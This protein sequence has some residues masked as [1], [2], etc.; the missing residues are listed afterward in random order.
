MLVTAAAVRHWHVQ[1]PQQL[2]GNVLPCKQ[3]SAGVKWVVGAAAAAGDQKCVFV[4][5][6]HLSFA[7]PYMQAAKCSA[8]VCL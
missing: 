2:G 1:W 5:F 7:L 8:Q 3:R 6:T 4:L